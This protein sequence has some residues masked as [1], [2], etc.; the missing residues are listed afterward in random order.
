MLS[1]VKYLRTIAAT[2]P[3]KSLIAEEL[4]PGPAVSRDEDLIHDLRQRSGTV[5]H[6]S[7]T[8]RMGPDPATSVVDPQL[9]VHGIEGLR[10]C[11]ASIFPNL[12]AGNTNAPSMMAGW[13]G[14]EII[15]SGR[16]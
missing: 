16:P 2:E 15:L 1:A 11:D 14:A 6:Q 5:Y 10:I 7:C 13:R 8:C 3:M 9:R 4:R 12:I